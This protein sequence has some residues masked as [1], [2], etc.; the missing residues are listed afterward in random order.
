MRLFSTVSIMSARL[1]SERG[2]AL[3]DYR[4]ATIRNCYRTCGVVQRGRS[5]H[6]AVWDPSALRGAQAELALV[7]TIVSNAYLLYCM[8]CAQARRVW[9]APAP[10]RSPGTLLNLLCFRI[11]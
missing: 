1:T 6:F 10:E 9:F 4:G 5:V 7:L 3:L 11:C 8:I 2:Y